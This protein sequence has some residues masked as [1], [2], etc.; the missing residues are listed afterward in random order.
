MTT[1]QTATLSKPAPGE[2][3]PPETLAYF[4]ARAKRQAYDL[5]IAELEATG[6]TKAEL[7]RRLGK[8]AAR[9]SRMLG[10][11]G[12]WT[13]KTASNLLF[14]MSGAT[15]AYRIDR[16]LDRPPRNFGGGAAALDYQRSKGTEHQ[17]QPI[18]S[19]ESA[20]KNDPSQFGAKQ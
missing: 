6:I 17:G 2:R 3:V 10:G 5:V 15:L 14:A 4:T 8:D 18:L 13:I 9:I 19:I 7:A 20:P 1:S 11:P 16:P 12:N